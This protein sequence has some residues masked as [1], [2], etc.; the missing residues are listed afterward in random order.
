M[1][2]YATSDFSQGC[3]QPLIELAEESPAD[4]VRLAALV[5]AARFPVNR[6]TLEKIVCIGSPLTD[7]GRP[8]RRAALRFAATLPLA[9]VREVLHHMM[10]YRSDV[11]VIR[12][13]LT[14]AG[15]LS[16]LPYWLSRA[17]Q[18]D[19]KAYRV[20]AAMPLEE[21]GLS[22]AELPLVGCSSPQIRLWH[23]LAVGRL[24][25][26]RAIERIA[27]QPGFA[28]QFSRQPWEVWLQVAA[29]RPF[30]AP[31]VDYLV[32]L[33]NRL[34]KPGGYPQL[35]AEARDA[36]IRTTRATL[37]LPDSPEHYVHPLLPAYVIARNGTLQD[38]FVRS[39]LSG[40]RW[41]SPFRIAGQ[42]AIARALAHVPPVQLIPETLAYIRSVAKVKAQ[43]AALK[44]LALTADCQAGCGATQDRDGGWH[45]LP[46]PRRRLLES[47]KTRMES[48]LKSSENL[49]KALGASPLA[50]KELPWA[51]LP[52]MMVA[53]NDR[54]GLGFPL[55]GAVFSN[56]GS[57][58]VAPPDTDDDPR[59]V[60]GIIFAEGEQRTTFLAGASNVFRCWIGLAV[61]DG[62]ADAD[63]PI[64]TVAIPDEGLEL[65]VELCWKDCRA[66]ARTIL[67][68]NRSAR[69]GDCD[70]VI[71]VPAN[72][73]FVSAEIVFRYRGRCFEAVTVEAAVLQLGEE[74]QPRD[75]LTIA[76]QHV[77]REI[78]GIDDTPPC[79]GTLLYGRNNAA[80]AAMLH[81]GTPPS[82]RL[83][84]GE[85]G[86]D[87]LLKAPDAALSAINDQLFA[88]TRLLARRAADGAGNGR[89]DT[90]DEEVR[91][92]LRDMARF[93]AV[94]YEQLLAGGFKDPGDRLQ[95]IDLE[96]ST[97][98]PIEFV[99]DRGSP[100]EN[101]TVCEG[102]FEALDGDTPGCP[103][104]SNAPLSN[105]QRRLINT[106]CPFG[107]WSLRKV[108][109]RMTPDQGLSAPRH[110]ARSLPPL[111]S[112]V[113]AS[114]DKVPEAQRKASWDVLQ[115][116]IP[117][118][119]LAANW[120]EWCAAVETHPQ[121]L[122]ALPH[123]GETTIEDYLE[124]GNPQILGADLSRLRRGQINAA[125]VN[126][127]GHE[128][129]PIVLLL[130]C[131][132]AADVELGYTG[133]IRLF[134]Q[135]KSALV[136]GTQAQVLG[137]DAAPLAGELV[138]QLLELNN[139][140]TDL[141]TA[142]R[143]V[144]RR[145]FGRGYLLALCLIA[146][147]DSAW[148]LSPSASAS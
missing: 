116:R 63:A 8:V 141:G 87:F 12:N 14:M 121:L 15:D 83:Y 124:I 125:C 91:I 26:H 119:M 140:E 122:V 61:D 76:V 52:T 5:A 136:L 85:G 74:A 108:I 23:S 66:S 143:R 132:T 29:A 60:R 65:S 7:R 82:L 128:P 77:R 16:L 27:E 46:Q 62:A 17:S 75:G 58:Y 53:A 100:S 3:L 49:R 88:A 47:S 134:L 84:S 70:L 21:A 137:R 44:I 110:M 99:Y 71:A 39:H 131:R 120:D 102:W 147:G 96:P 123:H 18:G 24:G 45:F 36:L 31:Q 90:G 55:S 107:F 22:F 105:R 127:D 72:E 98:W 9:S 28:E 114:S 93:G 118:A 129:G 94:L 135:Q 138:S 80:G 6:Y 64:P 59:C 41:Q 146:L 112:A 126:P 40:S 113:F 32:D 73:R 38:G 86:R 33:L 54:V 34:E 104:C 81:P 145:M 142:L 144:R 133:M 56:Y 19:A 106:I 30:P 2:T 68:V 117:M 42:A 109:E 25:D 97:L 78:L 92:L 130:G 111:V 67:P 95:L 51:D 35:T 20:L 57:H 148:Q 37:G 13:A 1:S 11:S 79:D 103:K 115:Q 10:H 139:G 50:T 69:S 101:A 48:F 4:S 89:L 43:V